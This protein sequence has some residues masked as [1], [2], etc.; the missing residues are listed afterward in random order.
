MGILFIF[1][2]VV[3]FLMAA[4]VFILVWFLIRISDLHHGIT[5]FKISLKV[6]IFYLVYLGSVALFIYN[7][8]QAFM[9]GEI[10]LEIRM[11]NAT[12]IFLLG[13]LT[14]PLYPLLWWL[15]EIKIKS[16]KKSATSKPVDVIPQEND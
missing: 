8:N 7:M 9:G 11:R 2:S 6:P 12:W 14:T 16:M 5:D 15:R 3:L 1:L 13:N 4:E 10:P